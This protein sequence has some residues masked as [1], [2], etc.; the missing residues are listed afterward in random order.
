MAEIAFK[1][2]NR[3]LKQQPKNIRK[4]GKTPGIIYGEFLKTPIP[5]QVKNNI[6]TKLLKSNSNGSIIPLNVENKIRNC[7]VKDVQKDH[8][9][10]LIHIDFQYVKDNEVIKMKIPVKYLGQENLE[11]KRLVL[12]TYTPFLEL[13]G[14]VEKIP[15]FIEFD[16]SNLN[17]EDKVFAKDIP[18]PKD[19]NLLTETETL[20]AIVNG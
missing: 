5:I 6:L 13:Q 3:S 2:D 20:L 11:N 8:L 10:N 17:Y 4:E 15:E 9:G 18:L 1:I 16:I 19:I 7:V 12:E 14:E